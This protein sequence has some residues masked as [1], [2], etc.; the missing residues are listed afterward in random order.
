[1]T[2]KNIILIVDDSQSNLIL[3][4]KILS[5]DGYDVISVS[6]GDDAIK[7]SKENEIDLILLDIMMPNKDG[8]TVFKELKSNKK[9]AYIPVI[10]ITVIDS[11]ADI[12]KAF[13]MGTVDYI[14][15][16]YNPSE[17]R[18]RIKNQIA[19]IN[20]NKKRGIKSGVPNDLMRNSELDP[21]TLL[22]NQLNLVENHIQDLKH[23]R[24][25]AKEHA[26]IAL[27]K[28]QASEIVKLLQTLSN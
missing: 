7:Y 25:N 21:L 8:F 27:L 10:F 3:L 5:N 1:M 28:M 19:I 24:F 18:L 12:L 22:S 16:P 2:K 4:D 11:D 17:L 26:N 13:E 23:A 14:S 9:T 15:K 6:N 20:A